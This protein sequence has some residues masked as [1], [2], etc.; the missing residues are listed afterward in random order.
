MSKTI[1][2]TLNRT[3]LGT[4]QSFKN[5]TV[6]PLLDAI[7]EGVEYL[8]LKEAFEK[9]W[10]E[11]DE[12]SEGGSVPNL[13]VINK[14]S[15]PIL[16]VDGEELKGAKQ[17]RIVNTSL[18]IAANSEAI[19]PVSCTE[20]GRW[21]YTSR[22][23]EDSGHIMSAKARYKKSMRVSANLIHA[24]SYNAEQ[25]KVW[26]DVE[27]LHRESRTHSN[28]SAM[29]DVYEQKEEEL[30]NYLNAFSIQPNQK[31][32]MLFLNGHLF[33][34]D[35]VS[36]ANAYRY[37]H[38][39]WIK[40][41]AIE[42]LNQSTETSQMIDMELEATRF[43]NEFSEAEPT[44]T[45]K[46]VGLGVDLRFDQTYWGGALLHY[47]DTPVHLSVFNKAKV[48]ETPYNNPLQAEEVG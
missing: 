4:P 13:K 43:L 22:S 20:A 28:T 24:E 11:I 12:V 40:S 42:A 5:L 9:Q 7:V 18:L 25:G 3:R 19:V 31:G 32:M 14:A 10:V 35:Y 39:K 29:R 15:V 37:L 36:S 17:N 6:F 38:E 16:L 41:H 45:H 44:S 21:Q 26:E 46:P 47:E 23:F 27:T 48:E 1:Q 34:V 30:S 33:A 2:N 8:S